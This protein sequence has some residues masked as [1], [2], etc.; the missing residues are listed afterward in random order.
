[1]G[2][3]NNRPRVSIGLPVF[4]GENYLEKAIQSILNQTYTD[5]ELIISDNASTDKTQ[6]ICETYSVQDRRIRY[7]RNEKNLGAA[8]NYNRVFEL[9]SGEYFKWAAHDD[10]LHPEFIEQSVTIL[11]QNPS[12][13]LCQAKTGRINEYDVLV[14]IYEEYQYLRIASPKP[15]E[16]F[17]DL[18]RLDHSCNIV[19]GLM[20]VDA[21]QKT[22]LIGSYPGSD[23]PLLAQLGLIGGFHEIPEILF[24]RRD[25]AQ[26]T[27]RVW[28]EKSEVVAWYDTTK[29]G[30]IIF[31]YWRLCFEYFKSISRIPLNWSNRLLCYVQFARLFK[32]KWRQNRPMWR[33]LIIDVGNAAKQVWFRLKQSRNLMT[34]A[35]DTKKIVADPTDIAN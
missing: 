3:E 2:I 21:L 13:V 26:T 34:A 18:I 10:V 4:N 33:W 27:W 7:F 19:F 17:F 6:Q 20:R 16:R 11:D 15:H 8:K 25:H 35:N 30:R 28:G 5:F 29:A 23:R 14:G 12:V 1:M 22:S 31:P 9:S 32:Q 24:Y